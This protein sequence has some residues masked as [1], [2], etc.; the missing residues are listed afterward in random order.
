MLEELGELRVAIGHVLF[1]VC[2]EGCDNL[3]QRQ[4]R[5][6]D[7]NRL[8]E[9][10][11]RG[12]LREQMKFFAARQ[13]DERQLRLPNQVRRAAVPPVD[14]DREEGVR[15]RGLKVHVVRAHHLLL[16]AR[17]EHL[18]HL[19]GRVALE[20]VQV[21]HRELIAAGPAD[22]EPLFGVLCGSRVEKVRDFLIVQLHKTALQLEPHR[23]PDAVGRTVPS[24]SSSSL[25]SV[26]LV[27]RIAAHPFAGTVEQ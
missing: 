19:V 12:V 6:V 2:R 1:A 22:F 5:G 11:L 27:G 10:L 20:Y 13:I 21:F 16:D 15:A 23:R 26:R 25:R 7:F 4:E 24:S 8:F 3:S 18:P 17:H 14:V 9:E